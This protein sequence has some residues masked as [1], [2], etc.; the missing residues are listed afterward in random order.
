[1]EGPALPHADAE[2]G[3]SVLDAGRQYV[4]VLV[5]VRGPEA[6]FVHFTHHLSLLLF[7]IF[8]DLAR[9]HD[10]KVYVGLLQKQEQS[11]VRRRD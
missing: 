11:A 7:L 2:L 1:V 8:G 3:G 6:G 10:D 4:T 5:S 9:V